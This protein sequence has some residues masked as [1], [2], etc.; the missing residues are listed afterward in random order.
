MAWSPTTVVA[1]LRWRR[2]RPGQGTGPDLRERGVTYLALMFSIVLIG[3]TLTA[4]AKPWKMVL[5]REQEADL[6]A[7]GIEIQQA[8]GAYSAKRKVGRAVPGEVYPASLEELTRYPEPLLRKVYRDPVT[9]RAWELVR[10]PTG[11]VMGVRSPSTAKPIRQH[12]FPNAVRHFENLKT[13]RDWIFQHPNP[14]GSTW[15][16]GMHM[17]VQPG[18][19]VVPA[20]SPGPLM[21]SQQA[22]PGGQNL[23]GFQS[24]QAPVGSRPVPEG[25]PGP[26]SLQGAGP[27]ALEVG[28]SPGV[29]STP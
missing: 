1:R 3:I 28:S 19:T 27:P 18:N 10:A 6:L 22:T 21:P 8:I 23:P 17:G 11:G 12:E 25:Q 2:L 26:S 5:Q 13:Y 20:G 15:P 14:S 4:A 9:R 16:Q 7:Y 29:P 24:E